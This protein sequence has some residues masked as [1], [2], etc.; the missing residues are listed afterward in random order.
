MADNRSGK[1]RNILHETN[2][3]NGDRFLRSR[4][5][6]TLYL[7]LKKHLTPHKTV[8]YN[9]A[10]AMG[11]FMNLLMKTRNYGGKWTKSER[12]ELKYYLLKLSRKIPVCII[13]LL[14]FGSFI[15]PL[16]PELMERRGQKRIGST[17]T[18]GPLT[19]G[20]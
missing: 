17:A 13:F 14:P 3:S 7:F 18:T 6:R 20:E 16:L 4:S 12:E 15:L 9:E 5:S 1:I 10:R 8:F 2:L 19:A 11:N